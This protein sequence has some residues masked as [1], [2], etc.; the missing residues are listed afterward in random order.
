MKDINTCFITK[1]FKDIPRVGLGS[2]QKE[3]LHVEDKEHD[4][5][6]DRSALMA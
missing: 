6:D 2:N 3:C 1:T 5:D 4:R